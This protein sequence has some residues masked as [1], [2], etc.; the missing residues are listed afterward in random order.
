MHVPIDTQLI[1][2]QPLI[3]S[4]LIDGQVSINSYETI[5]NG[6]SIKGNDRHSTVDDPDSSH[7]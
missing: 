7:W 6:L 3:N 4:Q 1:L 5:A 2:R